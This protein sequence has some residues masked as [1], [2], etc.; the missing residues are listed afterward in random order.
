MN[1]IYI[2][3]YIFPLKKYSNN[4]NIITLHYYI[5]GFKIFKCLNLL[6]SSEQF[7]KMM[8]TKNDANF[9]VDIV[10]LITNYIIC[11]YLYLYI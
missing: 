3:I 5:E 8:S 9:I 4:L 7:R 10:I 6:V 11:K 1:T 2:Y